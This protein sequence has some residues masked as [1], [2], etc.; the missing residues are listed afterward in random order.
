[1]CIFLF[2]SR[3]NVSKVSH[4][5]DAGFRSFLRGA[6]PSLIEAFRGVP[7]EP[8][9]RY[10]IALRVRKENSHG[11]EVPFVSGKTQGREGGGGGGGGSG[12]GSRTGSRATTAADKP[13]QHASSSSLSSSPK[14]GITDEDAA[15]LGQISSALQV[16]GFRWCPFLSTVVLLLSRCVLQTCHTM[17]PRT[18]T[19][20]KTC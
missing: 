17:T 6:P 9:T 14:L 20:T 12:S 10:T 1:M 16:K 4:V 18:R 2:F 5:V 8:E 3:P 7:L 13:M 15:F 19:C 11:S